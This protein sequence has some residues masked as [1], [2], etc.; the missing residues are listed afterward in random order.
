M[1]FSNA[2][3]P[4]AVLSLGD[5]NDFAFHVNAGTPLID[6]PLIRDAL[7]LLQLSAGGAGQSHSFWREGR[8]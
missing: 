6:E 3:D 2:F 4:R 1:V 8:K 7:L 5:D